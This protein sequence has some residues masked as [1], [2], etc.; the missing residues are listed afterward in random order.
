MH[1]PAKKKNNNSRT[2]T[3][4][5]HG[6]FHRCALIQITDSRLALTFNTKKKI[7]L[8]FAGKISILSILPADFNNSEK[9]KVCK[10][11]AHKDNQSSLLDIET[12][13][14]DC[15]IYSVKDGE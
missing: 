12:G 6:K 10:R 7:C 14:H 11:N 4:R 2:L 8:N 9:L 1:K 15:Y 5:R 3:S 13:Y